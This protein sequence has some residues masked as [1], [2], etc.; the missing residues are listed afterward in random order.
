MRHEALDKVSD[1]EVLGYENA[2]EMMRDMIARQ[3]QDRD[4]LSLRERFGYP[5]VT[6]RTAIHNPTAEL[7]LDWE[8][9]SEADLPKV[10]A[11]KYAEHPSTEI[12]CAAY[13]FGNEEPQLW[14]PDE[15]CPQDIVEHIERG[16]EIHAWNA[17]FERLIWL[18]VAGP[19]YGWPVPDLRQYRCIMV[20]AMA[21]NM[22]AKLEHAAPAFGLP[23]RKDDVGSRIIK[24]LCK[25]RKPSKKNPSTRFTPES[26]PE[27]FK[28]VYDYCLQDVRVEQG[29]GER[30]TKLIPFE[31]ELWFLDQTI[32]DRGI[33]VDMDLVAKA[34][35]IC[36]E[37]KEALEAE[38]RKVTDLNVQTLG[39][40][41]Q[42]KTWIN[43][44]GIELDGCD[45]E[46]LETLLA[47]DDLPDDIRR[48]VE[49]RLEAGKA[50]IAKL[51]AFTL[52][53]C[54][55]G[56]IKGS[57]Q[58]HGA[59]QT[60]RWA[61]RGVQLQ[62]LPRPDP[63]LKTDVFL[64]I[65]CI[66]DGWSREDIAAF[67]GPPI[68]VVADC[69]RGML[70]APEGRVLRS[71]DLT[72]IEARMLPWLAGAQEAIAAFFA[73]DAGLGEDNY[74]IAAAQIYNIPVSEVTKDQRQVGK[75]AVLALGFG[76]G[77]AA[78]A[79]MAKVYRIDLAAIF[80]TVYGI[81][82]PM[83]R[84]KAL[85]GWKDRGSKSGI[86]KKAWLTAE[87]VK[88]TWRENNPEIVQFWYDLEE[89]AINAVENP[90]K[91]FKAGEF[92]TF[93]KSGSFLRCKLPSGRSIFYPYPRVEWKNT[94]WGKQKP[95][96]IFKAIDSFT[97]KWAEQHYYGGL[98]AE[99]VTQA[100]AR[101]VMANAIVTTENAGYENVLSVHDEGVAESDEDFGSEEEFHELFT[102]P[103]AWALQKGNRLGL[104]IAASGWTDERYKKE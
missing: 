3:R 38:M 67:F 79:K 11:H 64:A 89:A 104:P 18:Y 16:G 74:K 48:A 100:A 90:G 91:T 83:N 26:D 9:F 55:D 27:K 94:P 15:P 4:G 82:S 86:R 21:M 40:V 81:T 2:A 70:M 44:R 34:E 80:D 17:N 43:S 32:N 51:A 56:K 92:I 61:A 46:K 78:F 22:P 99:N 33:M 5:A 62:N 29:V 95:T 1:W 45:K 59:T 13:A 65:R 53:V 49:I 60:G 58:Y 23:I 75:V 88:L 96:L 28:I 20:R 76:G 14:F 77:A 31:Q 102:T 39:A 84:E 35:R 72:G 63:K 36:N 8:T 37:E 50:S 57:L 25:P 73:F 12:L 6:R 98:G 93:K 42:L 87:M 10:G 24:Q 19:K 101:D 30:V 71:R 97:R 47:R 68:S 52:R 54:A 69:L 41:K 85:Q 66:K 103:P 7:H